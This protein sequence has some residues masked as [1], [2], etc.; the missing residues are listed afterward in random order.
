MY[1][2]PPILKGNE[3][4]QLTALR[5]YLVRMAQ[6]LDTQVEK[7]VV[8]T[9]S[10]P[11]IRETIGGGGGTV[12]AER[13]EVQT[14]R[15]LIIKTADT[16][17]QSIDQINT[18]LEMSTL[19]TSDF[20]TYREYIRRNIEDTPL[21]TIERFD[22]QLETMS[23]QLQDLEQIQG[24][25]R[26]G[27][28]QDPDNPGSRILGIAIA[29]K[30]QFTGNTMDDGGTTYYELQGAQTFG[31]YT[32]VGWQFWINGEKRGWF[33]SGDGMLHIRQAAIE[34]QMTLGGNWL[35]TADNGF[36]LRYI[37]T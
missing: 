13:R 14:L 20:G 9:V 11:V 18:V 6:S 4:E 24:E 25:I 12:N 8:Q 29:Q 34:Q 1:E 32:S 30:L 36:G 23:G 15:S 16:V 28:I 17:Q 33:D 31:F 10:S 5:D 37:G 27:F 19:A 21:A 3:R 22:A 7:V 35:L 2:L 26:R